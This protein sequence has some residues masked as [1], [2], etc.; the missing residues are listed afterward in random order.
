MHRRFGIKQ[1]TNEN[2]RAAYY[3][4]IRAFITQDWG[5]DLP[6]DHREI[7]SSRPADGDVERAY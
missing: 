7:W 6:L 4:Q 3:E 5:I 2:L 1:D